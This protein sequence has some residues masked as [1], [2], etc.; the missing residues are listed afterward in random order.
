MSADLLVA[1]PEVDEWYRNHGEEY[2]FEEGEVYST[3]PRHP[4][5]NTERRQPSPSPPPPSY[6]DQMM[7]SNGSHPEKN[8]ERHGSVGT[9]SVSSNR[10]NEVSDFFSL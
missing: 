2:N 1:S 8:Q 4:P 9:S 5:P 3:A 6:E 7:V 10:S